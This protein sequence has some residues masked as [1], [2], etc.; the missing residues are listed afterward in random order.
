MTAR[1]NALHMLRTVIVTQV[2]I[3]LKPSYATIIVFQLLKLFNISK[4]QN[5]L[6]LRVVNI[7]YEIH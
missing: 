1:T 6:L 5:Y 4:I 7:I 2:K 3:V